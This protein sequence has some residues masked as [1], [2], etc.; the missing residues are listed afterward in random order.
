MDRSIQ[1]LSIVLLLT[2]ASVVS[3]QTPLACGI[4]G[5]DGPTQV[6]PGTPM[7]FKAKITGM[8]HTTKPEFKWTLSAGE[9]TS[10]Q[11]TGE[12]SVDTTGLGGLNVSVTVELLGA[13]IGC[14]RSAAKKTQVEPP[15]FTCGL[16]FDQY[17]DIKFADEKARLDNFAFQISSEPLSTGYILMSAGQITFENETTE[18]LDRAKS[19]L[20]NVREIDSNRVVTVDCGFAK[21]LSIKLYLA[22]LGSTPPPCSNSSVEPFAEVKFT[23]RRPEASKKRR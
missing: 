7:V 16:P 18:R 11:G 12:I 8:I 3:A 21:E 23:K 4:V 15:V 2:L 5:I 10:G 6:S 14:N 13:S 1:I 20:V 17:G 19:Y 9:I 22:P